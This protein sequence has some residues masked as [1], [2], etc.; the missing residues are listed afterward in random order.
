MPAGGTASVGGGGNEVDDTKRR[1]APHHELLNHI[2]K[3][4]A[5]E[6]D[7]QDRLKSLRKFRL[8]LLLR[9]AIFVIAMIR[10]LY[11]RYAFFNRFDALLETFCTFVTVYITGSFLKK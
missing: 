10:N 1:N 8:W 9:E 2:T 7:L 5:E 11:Q 6:L 3:F 4:I